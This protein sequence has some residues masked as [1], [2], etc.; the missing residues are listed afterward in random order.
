MLRIMYEKNGNYYKRNIMENQKHWVLDTKCKLTH[1][2]QYYK[3]G[4]LIFIIRYIF[5]IL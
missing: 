1:H 2:V 4:K 3:V 5:T